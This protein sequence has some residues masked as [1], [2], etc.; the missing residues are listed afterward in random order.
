MLI[1]PSASNFEKCYKNRSSKNI[2]EHCALVSENFKGQYLEMIFDNL[3]TSKKDFEKYEDI[4][5]F[6]DINIKKWT[7]YK[8]LSPTKTLSSLISKHNIDRVDF[9]SL[10]TEGSE[11]DILSG[12]NLDS[13]IIKN[14]LVEIRDRDKNKIFTLLK[15]YN[16]SFITKFN[17]MDFLFSYRG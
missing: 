9:L 7:N 11:F 17:K 6:N 4:V 16:Y 15:K 10:D 13:G 8:F 3:R 1:E 12:S 5:K 2:F 14:I